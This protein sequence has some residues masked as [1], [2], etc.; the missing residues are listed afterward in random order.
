MGEI[1]KIVLL[2][3]LLLLNVQIPSK[4]IFIS[5]NFGISKIIC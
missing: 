2:N 1:V 3:V 4:F 5:F